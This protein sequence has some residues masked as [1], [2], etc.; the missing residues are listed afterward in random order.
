VQRGFE[1]ANMANP[2][3]PIQSRLGLEPFGETALESET[4]AELKPDMR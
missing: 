2:T 4:G 3:D 1:M